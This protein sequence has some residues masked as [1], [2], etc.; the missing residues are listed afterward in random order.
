[1]QGWERGEYPEKTRQQAAL[2]NMIPACEGAGVNPAGIEPGSPWWE[3]S[4]LATAPPLPL[5]YQRDN[6]IELPKISCAI[7]ILQLKTHDNDDNNHREVGDT[8]IYCSVYRRLWRRPDRENLFL[9]RRKYFPVSERIV[10]IPYVH[11]PAL[12]GMRT[13]D[14]AGIQER[15][16]KGDPRGNPPTNGIVWHENPGVTK[17]GVENRFGMV[18]GELSN[19]SASAAP[20]IFVVTHNNGRPHHYLLLHGHPSRAAPGCDVIQNTGWLPAS[21][22]ESCLKTKKTL[23]NVAAVCSGLSGRFLLRRTGFNS[24]RRVSWFSYAEI[25][26]DY[27]AGLRVFSGS[28]HFP[29]PCITASLHMHLTSPSTANK[30]KRSDA[31]LRGQSA[32]NAVDKTKFGFLVSRGVKRLLRSAT[33]RGVSRTPSRPAVTAQNWAPGEPKNGSWTAH[34]CLGAS[35]R[36]PRPA[37]VAERR[38]PQAAITP[39]RQ[40]CVS[41]PR[42]CTDSQ[43]MTWLKLS[44]L[45]LH[46]ARVALSSVVA[47]LKRSDV[48]TLS[49]KLRRLPT[50]QTSSQHFDERR[51]KLTDLTQSMVFLVS[52]IAGNESWTTSETNLK[53]VKQLVHRAMSVRS[54]E[55]GREGIEWEGG[56]CFGDAENFKRQRKK[57]A[58]T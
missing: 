54:N 58:P 4:A 42:P 55:G 8:M 38:R 45:E 18:G 51:R 13:T 41:K 17:P 36:R 27:A 47:S 31:Q 46:F 43:L 56:G 28:S 1:M 53:D 7:I 12:H 21:T 15:G 39:P 48:L 19:C 32:N 25:V 49:P 3:A 20:G 10:T 14:N 33:Y 44:R 37:S 52:L 30:S 34:D 11:K 29:R 26:Q 50:R 57:G 22:L 5:L 35:G 9:R 2:S 16:E 6:R 23:L 40:T 24:W